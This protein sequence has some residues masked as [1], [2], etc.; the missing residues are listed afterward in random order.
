MTKIYSIRLIKGKTISVE[1]SI[2]DLEKFIN[3]LTI[4]KF[5]ELK[6]TKGKTHIINN[7][8]IVEIIE[9]Y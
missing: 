3:Y 2:E 8:Y 7:N 6:D 5:I 4:S 9:I 1:Y